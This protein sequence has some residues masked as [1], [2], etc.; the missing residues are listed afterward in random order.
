MLRLAFC[1]IKKMKRN[2]IICITGIAISIMLLF[3]LVQIGELI[4]SNYKNMVLSVSSYDYFITGLD[5]ETADEIHERYQSWYRMTQFIPWARSLENSAIYHDLVGVAGDWMTIFQVELLEGAVPTGKNE[6]CLEQSYAEEKGIRV[7][8]TLSLPLEIGYTTETSA[9]FT[10]SGILSNI[11]AYRTGTFMLV[12]I[13][14]AENILQGIDRKQLAEDPDYIEYILMNSDG[15]PDREDSTELYSY[16][17]E[18]YGKD[19]LQNIQVN[20]RKLELESDQGMYHLIS[21]AI[22]GIVIF[23][24]VVMTIFIY[25]MMQISF[26]SKMNQY[27]TMRALGAGNAAIGRMIISELF[28]YGFVGLSLGCMAGILFNQIFAKIFI[29]IFVG[30]QIDRIQISY[31]MILYIVG[32]VAASIII[33]YLR[34]MLG[35]SKKKPIELIRNTDHVVKKKLFTCKNNIVEMVV[36]N[37][38]RNKRS[39]SALFVTMTLAFLAVLFLGNGLSSISFEFGDTMFAI[40]DMEVSVI[41]DMEAMMGESKIEEE[42]IRTL[43]QYADEVYYQGWETEYAAYHENGESL[44]RVW[45]YS[46]NLMEQLIR[47]QHMDRGTRVVFVCPDEQEPPK[48]QVVLKNGNGNSIPVMVDAVVDMGWSSLAGETAS[49]IPLIIIEEEYARELFG[50]EPRWVDVYLAGKG[51]N[52]KEMREILPANKYVINDLYNVMGEAVTQ[53][54]AILILITYMMVAL[55]GLVVFMITSIVKQNFEHRRKEI[56]MMRAIGASQRRMECML[57]GEVFILVIL[58]G[59]LA[60]V[61]AAPVSMHVYNAINE[62]T[63]MGTSGYLIGIPVTLLFCGIVIYGNVR[64]CMKEK[65]MEL[66]RSEG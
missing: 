39:S 50:R 18:T 5:K 65:T 43:A 25:Y 58:A 10:V 32:L 17:F 38:F 22:W 54:Q 59:M 37:S 15:F 23:I 11:G 16:I 26:Q 61:L 57:C 13:D 42:D 60:S 41:L 6:I 36:N 29:R 28:I 14:T 12:S 53:M 48:D 20:E 30:D 33:V 7:G 4:L 52:S 49:G 8:D 47:M 64:K 24:A 2:T 56:G 31:R 45:I 46:Q 40:A 55:M 51:L 44:A 35:L 9:D 63:G 62:E 27:G 1:Y 19:V 21:M 66:L 34:I 3:S